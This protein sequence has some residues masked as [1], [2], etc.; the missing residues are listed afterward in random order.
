MNILKTLN[1]LGLIFYF[2]IKLIVISLLFIYPLIIGFYY[3]FTEYVF[4][5]NLLLNDWK[6]HLLFFPVSI[7]YAIFFIRKKEHSLILVF[8]GIIIIITSLISSYNSYKAFKILNG[9]HS[10]QISLDYKSRKITTNDSLIFIG[11]TEKNIFL[12]NLNTKS[13]I[14]LKTENI[15][16]LNMRKIN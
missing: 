2:T 5:V 4:T 7:A 14:I 9:T 8:Y 16:N 13:N 1:F 15:E 12:R 6:S 11:K 3:F 10:Y